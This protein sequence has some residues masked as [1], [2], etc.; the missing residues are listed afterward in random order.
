MEQTATLEA[1]EAE[2]VRLPEVMSDM[3]I[4]FEPGIS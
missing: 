4:G 2:L 1:R 3:Q